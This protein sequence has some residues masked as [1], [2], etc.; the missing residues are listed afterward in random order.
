MKTT[1]PYTA[2]ILKALLLVNCITIGFAGISK[3]DAQSIVGKWNGISV[4]NY[5]SADYAKAAGK[6][7][8]TRTA[9]DA[10]TS[11]MEYKA[12]HTFVMTFSPLNDPTLTT[13]KGKWALTGNQLKLTIEPKYNPQKATTTAT[14]LVKGNV[15]TTTSLIAPP[16]RITRTVS[17]GIRM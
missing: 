5:F 8:E 9:S 15:I 4:T 1:S 12:D 14:V 7:M 13:I 6:N 16:S 11:T 3:C 17:T 2:F 10:G